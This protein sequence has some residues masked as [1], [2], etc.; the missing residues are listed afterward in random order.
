M[1]PQGLLALA[2]TLTVFAGCAGSDDAT[3]TTTTSIAAGKGAI[4]GLLIDDIYRPIPEALIVVQ[5]F[6]LTATTDEL[7][8][9]R[10]LDLDPGSYILVTSSPGHEAIPV[11]VDVVANQYTEVEVGARRIFSDAGSTVT[12]EYSVFI[13]CAVDYVVN[14]NVADCT[15]DTSGD[16][17]RPGYSS[18]YKAYNKTATYLIVEMLANKESR[19]EVQLREDDGSSAGG[20]RYAVAQFAGDYLRMQFKVGETNEVY[21]GQGNNKPFS[22]DKPISLILFAD[23]QGREELQ[24]VLPVCCGVGVH[25]GIK[26]RFIQTLFIGEPDSR[27]DIDRYCVL[28]RE[29]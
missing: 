4:T 26:A 17:Y 29:C 27:I 15:G 8:Q 1:N 28:G 24:G 22:L 11:N 23:S 5:G 3:T 25:F 14:G 7:G 16:S 10:F 6:G 9:F 18:D 2:L 21:N 20:D 19:Y 12:S 13:P